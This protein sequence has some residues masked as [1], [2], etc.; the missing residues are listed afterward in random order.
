M[1]KILMLLLP[2]A[3]LAGPPI[4]WSGST[5]KILPVSGIK[6]PASDAKR[7]IDL[8]TTDPTVSGYPAARGSLGISNVGGVGKLYL[9]TGA[10]DNQWAEK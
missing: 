7:I 6:F 1:L 9:K 5:A 10:A 3:V 8:G 4:I 2:C